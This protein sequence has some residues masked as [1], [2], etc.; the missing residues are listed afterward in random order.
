MDSEGG[1]TKSR[2]PD[3]KESACTHPPH[4]APPRPSSPWPPHSR[5]ACP[6]PPTPHPSPTK[7]AGAS[8][9]VVTDGLARQLATAIAT[10]ATRSR[11]TAAVAAGPVDLAALSLGTPFGSSRAAANRALR[12][13]KGLP[14]G[15][16]SLLRVRLADAACM[17]P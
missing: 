17:P 16:E 6:F 10:P 14:G 1:A 12:V 13:A 9:T 4:A 5:S 7:Y 11:V 8:V 15:E 3:L 2:A